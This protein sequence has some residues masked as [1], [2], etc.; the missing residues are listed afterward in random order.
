MMRPP[1][2]GNED[3]VADLERR[4]VRAYNQAD[5]DDDFVGVSFF[6]FAMDGCEGRLGEE[7]GRYA[8]GVGQDGQDEHRR[9]LRAFAWAF[10]LA[11]LGSWGYEGGSV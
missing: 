8:D 5:V 9:R 7:G 1:I 3:S 11:C 10:V 4:A 2:A 6:Y